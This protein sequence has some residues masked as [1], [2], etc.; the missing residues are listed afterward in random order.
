MNKKAL[1]EAALFVSDKPLSLEKLSEIAGISSEEVKKLITQLQ[2]ELI[3]KESGIELVETPEGFEFRVKQEY[4]EKV[5]ELAPLADLGNGMLRTLGIVAV[6][7]PIKQSVI[8][9]YQGNKVYGYVKSLEEKGLIKTEKFGR[10][11]IIRLTPEFERYFGKSS[12][13]IKARLG[14]DIEIIN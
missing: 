3:K 1:L 14:K 4:R 5:A 6:K 7:Q 8:V 9:K 12:E 13:E 10:T 11:K 2:E